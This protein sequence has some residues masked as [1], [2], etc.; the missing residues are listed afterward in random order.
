[1]PTSGLY[2]ST[3]TQLQAQACA[4]SEC[5]GVHLGDW[6]AGI[7]SYN[8]IAIRPAHK[9]QK[10][11][12]R[13]VDIQSKELEERESRVLVQSGSGR[14]QTSVSCPGNTKVM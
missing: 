11:V 7:T 13:V 2:F 14:A 1:M 12:H 9:S 5:F 3:S 6:V 8:V 4:H 10:G